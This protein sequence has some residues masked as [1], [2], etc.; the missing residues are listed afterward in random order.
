MAKKH[1]TLEALQ[2]LAANYT[3]YHQFRREQSAAFQA[4][5]RNKLIDQ[6]CAHMAKPVQKQVPRE[7]SQNQW[8]ASFAV[9]ERRYVETSLDT[10]LND[11][12]KLVPAVS[13]RPK[14]MEGMVFERRVFSA[15]CHSSVETRL[16]I[17]IE[18]TS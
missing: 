14:G 13:R 11:L 15:A 8:L 6:V 17:C 9:G 10:Y 12:P 16:L 7:G 18:R 2:S 4:A 5:R 1:W 3:D